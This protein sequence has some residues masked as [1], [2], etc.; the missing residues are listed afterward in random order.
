MKIKRTER[1]IITKYNDNFKQIERLCFLS[2]NLYNYCNY[3]LRQKYFENQKIE[4]KKERK[5]INEYELTT[6]LTKENQ[7]DFRALP[8]QTSQQIIKLLFK[9]WKSFYKLCKTKDLNGR[10]QIPKYKKKDGKNIII[11]TNQ[12]VKLKDGFINFPKNVNLS[13]VR[14]T[15]DNIC[16]IRIIPDTACYVLEIIYEKEVILNENLNNELYLAIDLGVNNF[17]TLITNKEG[18]EPV[19][20]NGKI[21]KSINQFYNK[22]KAALM[23]VIMSGK[24]TKKDSKPYSKK[25]KQL[26]F[27]RNNKVNDY[28]HKA[29]R[30][31]INYCIK[32]N[33]KNIVIGYNEGWKNEINIGKKNNQ[34][35]VSIPYLKF[36]NRVKYKAEEIGCNI[37]LNNESFTSKC[38]AL[39]EEKIRKHKEYSGK[40][41]KRGLFQSSIGKL[42]NAD[43]NGA[44]N[45]LRKV[46]GNS[47]VKKITNIGLG[48]RPK[49]V[50]IYSI[51]GVY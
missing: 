28:I 7:S 29:S 22:K 45:I 18:L 37:I 34:K 13:A 11:F 42:I 3:I 10:P 17:S 44:I 9:N 19:L 21:I 49:R 27:K 12:Q 15:V 41:I 20:I 32:H 38:D 36:I 50:N 2:K 47:F 51:K 39:A 33:I 6:L 1:H 4:D 48:F 40:R 24:E 5:Y 35:F 26:D 25:L 43:I 16:S 31:V 23:S 46:I 14:T 8:S 30:F